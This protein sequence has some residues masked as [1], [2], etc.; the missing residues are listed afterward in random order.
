MQLRVVMVVAKAAI[1]LKAAVTPAVITRVVITP[2]V[3]I[4]AVIAPAVTIPTSRHTGGTVTGTIRPTRCATRILRIA[5]TISRLRL[6]PTWPRP[7]AVRLR[8]PSLSLT[9]RPR[10]RRLARATAPLRSTLRLRPRRAPLARARATEEEVPLRQRLKRLEPRR[11]PG[12]FAFV[13][14]DKARTMRLIANTL[15]KQTASPS[16]ASSA[17]DVVDLS[18]RDRHVN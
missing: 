18:A 1:A 4:R 11:R 17:V 3:I 12:F 9:R 6:R 14:G 2:V 16:P 7:T 8:L 10:L 15:G 5:R 13:R